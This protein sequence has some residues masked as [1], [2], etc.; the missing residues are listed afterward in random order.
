VTRFRAAVL[1]CAAALAA[2]AGAPAR[3]PEPAPSP[4]GQ[5]P[6]P[7]AQTPA[8]AGTPE[9]KSTFERCHRATH[10][11]VEII[12][13]AQARV[14]ETV[15]GAAL[16]FDGLFGEGDLRAARAAHGRIEA[17]IA[18]SDFEG[19]QWRVRFNAAVKFPALQHRASAFVG[20]EDD[21]EFIRDRSEGVGLRSQFPRV[22]DQDEWLAGLGYSLPEA[23]RVHLDVKAG[24]HGIT[25]PTGF[26]QARIGYTAWSDELS[27]VHLRGTPFVNT[28]Y[29]LGFTGSLD[30]DHAFGQALLWRWGTIGTI[31]QKSAG[32]DWRTAVILYQNLR[33]FRALGYELFIR[34]ATR[35]PEPIGEY[36]GRL[37]YRQPLLEQRL[38]MQ[39]SVGY[40]WPRTD[41]L[42]PR[43]GSASVSIS[44][45]MPFGTR[46]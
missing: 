4:P 39:P 38:W 43:A 7:P 17:A 21:E 2:C 45:E 46:S 32:V 28:R 18:H 33:S 42:L 6:A 14:Q 1:L 12:D 31:S 34:G 11:D 36:G 35:A 40:S 41:P 30:V 20:R 5:T 24:A 9:E 26:V 22:A 25:N 44:V 15:C 23:Y 10:G 27:L 29:G 13:E 37:I 3:P 19:W 16:W 8:Q